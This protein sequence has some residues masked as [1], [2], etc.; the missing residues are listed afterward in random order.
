M[1]QQWAISVKG[2]LVREGCVLLGANDRGEWE[3][4]GG[5]IEAGETPEEALIREFLEE[6]GLTVRPRRVVDARF[7]K[8]TPERSVFL[9]IFTVDDLTEHLEPKIS[10]EHT[11]LCWAPWERLPPQLPDAYAEPIERTLK[12][13]S[14]RVLDALSAR[15]S[16]DGGARIKRLRD[17]GEP[18]ITPAQRGWGE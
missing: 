12:G 15:L 9:V 16:R 8:P 11:D 14:G 17:G 1:D 13:L 4:P 5:R 6:T 7:L 3:L 2:I 10:I 18:G